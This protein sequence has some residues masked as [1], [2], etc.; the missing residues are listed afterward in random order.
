MNPSPNPHKKN[1]QGHRA[2]AFH[3]SVSLTELSGLPGPGFLAPCSVPGRRPVTTPTP[4]GSFF[5][6]F[7]AVGAALLKPHFSA[8]VLK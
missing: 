3:T 5:H 2:S 7:G 1:S 8:E 6:R 4:W